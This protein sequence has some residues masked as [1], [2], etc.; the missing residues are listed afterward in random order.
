M[1]KLMQGYWVHFEAAEAM[2]CDLFVANDD[3]DDDV[4]LVRQASGS[5]HWLLMKRLQLLS[6]RVQRDRVAAVQDL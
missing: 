3:H 4:P 2:A 6:Q 1:K 5:F